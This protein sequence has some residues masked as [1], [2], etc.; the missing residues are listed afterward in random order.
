MQKDLNDENFQKY[1]EVEIKKHL[2]IHARPASEVILDD[3]DVREL[4]KISRRT[5]LEYRKKKFFKFFKLEIK[6]YYFL[7]DIIDGIKMNG[8]QNE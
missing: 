7:S 2:E 1:L 5:A 3:V 4:L 8:G 6:I